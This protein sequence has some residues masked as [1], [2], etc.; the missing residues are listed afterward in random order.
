MGRVFTL[1]YVLIGGY[2][3]MEKMVI[4]MA[5]YNLYLEILFI[6]RKTILAARGPCVPRD[7]TFI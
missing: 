5:L 3:D 7:F 1:M 2:L 4:P 6:F